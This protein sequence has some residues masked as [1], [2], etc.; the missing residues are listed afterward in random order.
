MQDFYFAPVQAKYVRLLLLKGPNDFRSFALHNFLIYSSDTIGTTTRFI[1]QSSD[2]DGQIVS[3]AWNFGDGSTS[4]E[5][6]PVHTFA[7][8]G[9]YTVTLTV[10]DNS[11]LTNI[12]SR[13]YHVVG[14]LNPDFTV[15]PLIAH[16]G[17]ESVRFADLGDLLLIPSA[18]RTY[19]FGDGRLCSLNTQRPVSILSRTVACFT[20]A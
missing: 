4:T 8:A 3:W 9:D 17:G 10:A 16:E 13:V 14:S 15:S 6:H 11:G 18:L 20:L 7:A 5:R 12:Y 2:T 1:D 19:D